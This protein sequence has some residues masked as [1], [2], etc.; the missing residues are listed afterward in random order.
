MT[1]VSNNLSIS[2]HLKMLMCFV[3]ELFHHFVLQATGHSI[4][5]KA[6]YS[7]VIIIFHNNVFRVK[8]MVD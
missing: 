1:Q 3:F 6:T 4:L 2:T 5:A 8:T 7:D